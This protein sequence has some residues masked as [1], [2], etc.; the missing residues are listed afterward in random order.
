MAAKEEGET[1]PEV[2][3][4]KTQYIITTQFFSLFSIKLSLEK[5]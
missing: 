1:L 2:E 4:A 5:R 3:E